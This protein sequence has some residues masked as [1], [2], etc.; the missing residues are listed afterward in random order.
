MSTETAVRTVADQEVPATGKW[1]ID[2]AHSSIEAVARHLMVSKVR[3]HF[4]EY[5]GTINVAEDIEDSSVE[6]E[7]DAASIDTRQPDRDGHLR[8][9][10][11][12]DVE[13]HPKIT[14]RST[15]VKREGDGW[16][17]DG[18]LTIRGVTRPVTL[19]VEFLGVMPNPFG[20][21]TAAFTA[22]TEL[23]REN[24]DITWNQAL[25]TGGVLV[26]KSLKVEIDLQASRAE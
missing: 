19:D 22:T 8:S 23:D 17:M 13:N 26:G 4:S 14:F 18:D 24:W 11:F 21:T 1:E 3:G 6:V 5:S 10:D 12:L 9:G 20:G 15:R 25:E 16:K 2:P 7:I